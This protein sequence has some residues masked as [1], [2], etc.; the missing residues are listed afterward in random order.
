MKRFV[1]LTLLMSTQ[2][3]SEDL[4]VNLAALQ[5]S[6]ELLGNTV[7]AAVPTKNPEKHKTYAWMFTISSLQEKLNNLPELEEQTAPV[8]PVEELSN[9]LYA[10]AEEIKK[11]Q[12]SSKWMQGNIQPFLNEHGIKDIYNLDRKLDS[13]SKYGLPV[14]KFWPFAQKLIVLNPSQVAFWGDLHGSAQS[15]A[16][17][18]MEL[19]GRNYLDDNFKIIKDNFYI[20]FL[21]DYTDRGVYGAEV[22]YMLARLKTANPNTMFMARGNHEDIEIIS[23]NGF[24]GEL[25][26]K[27][28]YKKEKKKLLKLIVNF[29]NLLPVALYL[30]SKTSSG[31]DF[32]QCCHG[33]MEPGYNPTNFLMNTDTHDSLEFELIKALDR[34]KIRG[35]LIA[36]TKDAYKRYSEKMKKNKKEPLPEEQYFTLITKCLSNVK[37]PG[38]NTMMYN[39]EDNDDIGSIGFMWNDFSNLEGLD[40]NP[41]RGFIFGK[42]PTKMLLNLPQETNKNIKLNAVIRAHQH[43]TGSSGFE[44]FSSQ[45]GAFSLW[46]GTVYTL[47][48]AIGFLSRTGFGDKDTFPYDTFCIL[49]ITD[50]YD[51]WKLTH[52]YRHVTQLAGPDG[53]KADAWQSRTTQINKGFQPFYGGFT[54]DSDMPQNRFSL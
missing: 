53:R 36:L 47:L 45:K 22:L 1:L 11:I 10:A 14:N 13:T 40:Y 50:N 19:K 29:Y 20:I 26:K 34:E 37:Y 35:N 3:L 48:S 16:A 54:H 31:F 43:N 39:D 42:N 23:S 7:P 52:W 21:G 5:Q 33:G 2:L 41:D 44:T 28:G 9:S 12:E 38:K 24:L 25:I 46:N 6:F 15:L 4:T 49:D 18:L 51:T 27:Y 32:I 30:G 17:D 8:I